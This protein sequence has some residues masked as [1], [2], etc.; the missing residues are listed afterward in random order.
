LLPVF[1]LFL[2]MIMHWPKIVVV[3]VVVVVIVII[4][5]VVLVD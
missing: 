3:V 4:V 5:F 2:K 1:V